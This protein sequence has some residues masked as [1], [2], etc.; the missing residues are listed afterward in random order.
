MSL[1]TYDALVTAVGEWV[2]KSNNPTLVARIPTWISLAE[3]QHKADIDILEMQ[4]DGTFET[5]ANNPKFSLSTNLPRFLT[6]RAIRMTSGAQNTLD[7][8]D[9]RTFVDTYGG[10]AAGQPIDYTFSGDNILF[11]PTPNAAYPMEIYWTQAFEPLS[12]DNP[13]NALLT[14]SPA[15]YLYGTLLQAPAYLWNDERLATF[16]TFYTRATQQLNGV[17]ERGQFSGAPTTITVNDGTLP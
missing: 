12:L 4:Q 17:T 13:T 6:F 11:G 5:V 2:R 3:E 10:A 14:R 8:K 1:G 15:A 9:I 7:V 16:S